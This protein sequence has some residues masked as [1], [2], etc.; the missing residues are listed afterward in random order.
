M[1]ENTTT[2][3]VGNQDHRAVH[4]FGKAHVGNVPGTQVDLRWRART[5]DHDH[6][7]GSTQ[8]LVGSQHRLHGDSLVVVVGHRVHAGDGAA[9]DDHLGAGIA[10]GLEQHRVHVCMRL[11]AAG[12]GLHCLGPADF[13][14][15]GGHRAVQ[16]HVL[17]L[18]R[19]HANA[20]AQQPAAQRGHQ[21]AFAGVGGGALHHEGG[22]A[23]SF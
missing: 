16:R 7:P 6:R 14:A 8:A 15:V 10:V 9:M 20:L 5:F 3:D 21:R 23:I 18:E 1:G 19:H 11:Q 17:R 13:T 12:L 4:R 22:H 2:I